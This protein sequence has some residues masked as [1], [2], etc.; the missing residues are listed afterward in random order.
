MSWLGTYLDHAAQYGLHSFESAYVEAIF[1][2][3]IESSLFTN[4]PQ[5]K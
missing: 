1:C 2:F 5:A 3:D 4:R